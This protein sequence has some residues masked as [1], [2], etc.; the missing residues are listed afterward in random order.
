MFK[1][2]ALSF[3]AVLLI[4]AAGCDNNNNNN[5][6]GG[7][8][9]TD[10]A[11]ALTTTTP[12]KHLVVIF[13]ENVSFDHYFGT[14][15]TATNPTGE[16]E[17]TAAAGT[18]TVHGLSEIP[19]PD[20]TASN[21]A[22]GA[23]ATA[24]FRLDYTQAAT[25]DQ[26]HAY[27]AEQFAFD[28]L[29]MDLFP[30]FTGTATTGGAAA[31]GTTG[32]VMGYYDG[33]TVTA[34]WNY[35]Q[36]YAMSDNSY[37]TT[38]GPST[39]GALNLV[40]GQTNGAVN[41]TLPAG[42]DGTF[43]EYKSHGTTAA[44]LLPDGNGGLTDADDDDPTGDVC[45]SSTTFHMTGKNV[46]DLLNA[47]NITWG[48]FEGGFDLT[49]INPNGTTGCK[50]STTSDVT[51]VKKADYIPHHQPFQYYPSTANPKHARPSSL[52][53][54]GSSL[55]TDGQTPEPANHQYDIHDFFDA[56]SAG[57]LPSVSYLKAAGFQDGHAGYSDPLDEQTFVTTVINT[58]QQS[59]EWPTTMVVIAYD[60]S[61][62][63]FDHRNNI[64]NGSNVSTK[65]AVFDPLTACQTQTS[66]LTGTDGKT[67]V[68]GRCGYGPRL[69]LLVIS[70]YAKPNFVDDTVTA[71]SSILK[72]V[73][74]NW[75]GGQ[76]IN[77]SFD[78]IANPLTNML[79]TTGT[80]NT[81]AF[82]LDPTTG[83][84]QS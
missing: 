20:P 5:S 75:L 78:S 17:F 30:E 59:P 8:S 37:G 38:F 9:F 28:Q 13:Q 35:A 71:Q 27:P 36:H 29:T 3:A 33:N 55:E 82:L 84:P 79:N 32:Q 72:F 68:Q 69:P 83:E 80:P 6:S 73:E 66:I 61:D 15:P 64:V 76:R 65:N 34:L 25:S 43:D 58:L 67:K 49:V 10:P 41:D 14:Y 47:A 7:S 50:R 77:G 46:G 45:S 42:G 4:G 51:G 39:T 22:N 70:P 44:T 63:W 2:T 1:R 19:S 18:P 74:D 24:P 21:A 54:I 62:G 53:A 52:A 11:A 60:D 81:K 26:D 56:L 48:F 23:G 40:S 12:I 57:N 31:F 16:P